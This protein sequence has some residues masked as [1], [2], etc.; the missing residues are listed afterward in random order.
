MHRGYVK[1]IVDSF[2]D[3]SHDPASVHEIS[4]VYD[5][6]THT[7]RSFALRA[8][9][10]HHAATSPSSSGLVNKRLILVYIRI[11][12]YTYIRMYTYTYVYILI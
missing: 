8:R 3:G 11:Y 2:V 9:G 5:T 6:H 4:C 7:H 10:A 12:A 1:C